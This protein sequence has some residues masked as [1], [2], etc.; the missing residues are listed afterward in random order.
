[1]EI[2]RQNTRQKTE[3]FEAKYSGEC[4]QKTA[5]S[6]QFSQ[7]TL[8]K[9]CKS[10]TSNSKPAKQANF[11]PNNK[12]TTKEGK[13]REETGSILRVGIQTQL[14][15]TPI[16]YRTLSDDPPQTHARSNATHGLQN[17][18]KNRQNSGQTPM[19]L[20]PIWPKSA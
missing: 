18:A 13:R 20:R 17:L 3:K 6:A 8:K 5:Q 10:K 7:K 1:M 19:K 12:R 2:L 14:V 9:K 4:R 15:R 11:R 16:A